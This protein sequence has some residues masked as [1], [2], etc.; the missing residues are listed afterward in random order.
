MDI[1]H[2]Y[3]SLNFALAH[4]EFRI[5][6]FFAKDFEIFDTFSLPFYLSFCQQG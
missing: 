2:G 5:I 6:Y 3:G 1:L 4:E